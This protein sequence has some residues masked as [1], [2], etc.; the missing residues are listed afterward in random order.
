MVIVKLYRK[1]D[2][3]EFFKLVG[4]DRDLGLL[5]NYPIEAPEF[6]RMARWVKPDEVFIEWVRLFKEEV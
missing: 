6:K 5:L 2:K 4:F 1:P 3:P